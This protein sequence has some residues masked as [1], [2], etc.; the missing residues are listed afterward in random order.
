MDF[1]CADEIN[2]S[3]GLEL[4]KSLG[5]DWEVSVEQ[6]RS[7]LNGGFF[8][9]LFNKYKERGVYYNSYGGKYHLVILVV[10]AMQFGATISAE[11]LAYARSIYKSA[12]LFQES[13]DQFAKALDSYNNDGTPYDF[14][15]GGVYD[16]IREVNSWKLTSLWYEEWQLRHSLNTYIM[17]G[18][19]QNCQSSWPALLRRWQRVC[20]HALYFRERY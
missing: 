5:G 7:H 6:A 2:T 9:E 12:G 3:C 1:D 4:P 20:L 17:Q 16:K 14:K 15:P 11:Q 8:D 19:T 18:R 13:I 10:L